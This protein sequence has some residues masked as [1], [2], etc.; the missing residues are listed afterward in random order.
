MEDTEILKIKEIAKSMGKTQRIIY[1]E[2]KKRSPALMAVLSFLIPGLGQ[3]LQ[4]KIVRG[5]LFFL[6]SWLIIPWIWSIYDAY[7]L[8]KNYNENLYEIL[9]SEDDKKEN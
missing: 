2:T 9:F 8:A 1:Y 7:V 3:I 6:F 4:G 5:I